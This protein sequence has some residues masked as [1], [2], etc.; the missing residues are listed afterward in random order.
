MVKKIPPAPTP[1]FFQFVLTFSFPAFSY[2]DAFPCTPD[3][4]PSLPSP[5]RF[6]F[7]LE[8]KP[9]VMGF[10]PPNQGLVFPPPFF[11]FFFAAQNFSCFP[12]SVVLLSLVFPFSYTYRRGNNCPL[13]FPYNGFLVLSDFFWW[14]LSCLLFTHFPVL[15]GS[16]PNYSFFSTIL[17]QLDRKIAFPLPPFFTFCF[18]QGREGPLPSSLL[19]SASCI[20]FSLTTYVRNVLFVPPP[21]PGTINGSGFVPRHLPLSPE[22]SLFVIWLS[23]LMFF[24]CFSFPFLFV[25]LKAKESPPQPPS[26]LFSFL[27]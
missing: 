7:F 26:F 11:Y 17:G 10:C 5:S 12:L 15:E 16:K 18:F 21:A 6:F 8:M 14:P 1:I 4:H 22:R 20:P 3:P 27:Y 2:W 25:L 19:P 23:L 9:V 13:F 24:F